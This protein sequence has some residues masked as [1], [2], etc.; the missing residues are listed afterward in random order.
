MSRLYR[1]L[2]QK[3]LL[4]L[5]GLLILEAIVI[6]FLGLRDELV[7][8]ELAVVPGTTVNPDGKP[9]WRLQGRLDR[10][11]E[12]YQGGYCRSILVSGG[13][14]VEGFD[15]AEVMKTFL[16]QRGVP[17]EA[18][19]TDHH[20]NTTLATARFT[21]A[22]I[23]EKKW[24]KPLLVSQ[25]FHLPRFRLAMAKNGVEAGG[26]A[27]SRLYGWRDLYS[28]LREVAGYPVYALK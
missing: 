2:T 27:H 12:L 15:E 3:V 8:T 10:A 13:L 21:A 19:Y 4:G 11:L 17:A 20:G 18:I 14:G 5:A 9:S 6:S 28:L 23:K 7:R 25:F 1:S 24:D 16:V 26:Q 22:L